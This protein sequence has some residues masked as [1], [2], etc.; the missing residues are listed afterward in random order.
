MA[1]MAGQPA[2]AMR[3]FA[4]SEKIKVLQGMRMGDDDRK[5]YEL[6][7]AFLQ[8][9]LAQDAIE[10]LQVE[11]YSTSLEEIL[12]DLEAWQPIWWAQAKPVTSE[13]VP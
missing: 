11:G 13:P 8:D 5:E 12:G 3:L 10:N 4:A 7:L 6:Y 2:R 9:Q 1:V